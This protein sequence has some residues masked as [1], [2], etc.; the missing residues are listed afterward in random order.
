MIKY[1]VIADDLTGGNATSVLL[2]KE[3]LDAMT[4]ISRDFKKMDMDALI[5]STNSRGIEKEEAYNRV[6]ECTLQL[7]NNNVRFFSKRIDSTMRGNIGAEIDAMLDAL[8]EHS[9]ALCT[10][11][12]PDSGR[13]VRQGE[14]FVNGVPLLHS[15]V[16]RDPKSRLRTSDVG[17]I[18]GEQSK[19]RISHLYESDLNCDLDGICDRIN[20]IISKGYRIIVCDAESNEQIE[21]ISKAI[22]LNNYCL[23]TADP[24]TLT[25]ARAKAALQPQI[26]V[27]E[28]K[29]LAIIGSVN[30]MARLQLEK[31]WK[32]SV[33]AGKV[34]V[35]TAALMDESSRTEEICRVVREAVRAK[36]ECNILTI[37][38]DG[39]YPEKRIELT[40]QLSEL[41][42]RSFGDIAEK[43]LYENRGFQGLYTS[44]GDIT[45]AVYKKFHAS[46]IQVL[47]EVIPLA[48]YG[49]LVGGSFDG[50]PVVTKGGSQGNQGAMEKCVRYLFDRVQNN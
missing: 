27:S 11:A 32:S 13:I 14:L 45:I 31:L 35:N 49:R 18:I 26:P 16:A 38:S 21:K 4:C 22:A 28:N 24:G 7:K 29:V 41:I 36:E 33:Q 34:L 30:I 15:E 17:D 39:I 25:A 37:V 47:D 42:N 43:L 46:G 9:A 3:G 23:I 12:Y 1:G 8:G 20:N 19:Y 40:E 5:Y 50:F 44:G 10:P 2:K 48:V 6:F